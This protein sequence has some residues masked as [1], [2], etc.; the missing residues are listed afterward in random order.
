ML[1]AVDFWM[2][3]FQSFTI[4]VFCVC[5]CVKVYFIQVNLTNYLKGKNFSSSSKF[6]L[7]LMLHFTSVSRRP[8]SISKLNQSSEATNPMGQYCDVFK[9]MQASQHLKPLMVETWNNLW[10][11][12]ICWHFASTKAN[13][14]YL[15]VRFLRDEIEAGLFHCL[16]CKIGLPLNII[17]SCDHPGKNVIPVK[18]IENGGESQMARGRCKHFL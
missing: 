4:V 17:R 11:A 13:P 6:M 12:V 14:M 5:I 15:A 2:T 18:M 16:F 10:L 9:C 7:I 1:C 8:L 3:P